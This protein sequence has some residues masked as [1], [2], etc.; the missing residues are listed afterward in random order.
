LQGIP[1][2]NA[3]EIESIKQLR[4]Q[5]VKPYKKKNQIEERGGRESTEYWRAG[6]Q[7]REL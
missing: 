5:K 1:I 4:L 3:V 6:C 7:L 2:T